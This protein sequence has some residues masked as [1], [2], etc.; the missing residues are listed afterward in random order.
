MSHNKLVPA[1]EQPEALV[2]CFAWLVEAACEDFDLSP[3]MLLCG[4][5]FKHRKLS[6]TRQRIALAMRR[7]T[8]A[9]FPVIGRLFGV[10]HSAIW[11]MC[12]RE[13]KLEQEEVR[14]DVHARS[15]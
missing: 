11:L 8:G 7:H 5:I 12:Q 13:A 10:G 1:R 15:D 6:A 9:S 2:E 4:G 14:N 3:D